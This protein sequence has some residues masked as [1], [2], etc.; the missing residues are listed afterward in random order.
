MWQPTQSNPTHLLTVTI[1][2]NLNANPAAETYDI[3]DAM[4]EALKVI[5][6][7]AKVGTLGILC[8]DPHVAMEERNDPS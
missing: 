8:D 2:L 4:Q 5:M 7:I 1:P 6:P 3:Q